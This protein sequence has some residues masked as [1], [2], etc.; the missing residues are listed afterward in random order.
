LIDRIEKAVMEGEIPMER[1]NESYDRI[2]ALK[3]KYNLAARVPVDVD[4]AGL[5][6]GAKGNQAVAVRASEAALLKNDPN[7]LLPLKTGST[8]AV[9]RL[10]VEDVAEIIRIAEGIGPNYA[11]AYADFVTELKNAGFKVNEF[12]PGEAIPAGE[13]VI[14]VS[15][16]YPLPG[17]SLDLKTQR[18]RMALVKSMAKKPLLNVAL[19]DPYDANLIS[20]DAW[21]CA[22]GS[23]ISNIRAVVNLLAGKVE[24]HGKWPVSPV[25]P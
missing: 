16:N 2:K 23:N 10:A 9:C 18:E 17:K 4:K 7:N 21:V 20:A 19:K 13:V 8:V 3:E 11:N 1:I 6:V 14:A 22:V 15:E 5:M 12:R 25:N 24:A